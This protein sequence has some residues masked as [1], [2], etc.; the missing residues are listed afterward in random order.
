MAETPPPLER[1]DL[2]Q[3]LRGVAAA[4]IAEAAKLEQPRPEPEPWPLPLPEPE[5]EPPPPPAAL[6]SLEI[7]THDPG[8]RTEASPGAGTVVATTVYTTG[9]ARVS[10]TVVSG[11]EGNPWLGEITTQDTPG[12]VTV[13]TPLHETG[14]FVKYFDADDLT[15]NRDSAPVDLTLAPLPEPVVVVAAFP[16]AARFS[17]ARAF[18]ARQTIGLNVERLRPTTMGLGT[19]YYRYLG[20]LGVTHCRFFPPY[21]YDFMMGWAGSPNVG[22]IDTFLDRVQCCLDAGLQAYLDM[23]DVV[24]AAELTN[25]WSTATD[26]IRRFAGRIA[27]RQMDPAMIAVGAFNELAGGVNGDFNALRLEA[28]SIIHEVLP[29]H[30]TVSGGAYWN[31]IQ[32][33]EVGDW[34]APA[35]DQHIAQIHYYGAPGTYDWAL[36][37]AKFQ[38]LGRRYGG[39]PFVL[40]ELADAFNHTDFARDHGRWIEL[41]K[42]VAT[43][44]GGLRPMLWAQAGEGSDFRLNRSATDARMQPLIEEAIRE[45]ATIIKQTAGP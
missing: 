15:L 23:F 42:Q 8:P 10:S 22:T 34:A 13:F 33:W 6:R 44:A 17:Q 40:G 29:A 18:L 24:G 37:Y 16:A 7:E 36:G 14:A 27:A 41:F 28:D 21:R 5:S 30:L 39:M 1:A 19:D 2:A 12:V 31:S 45:C 35:H 25:N 38:A 11:A 3:L 26:Y 9:V 4:L 20:E 32:G 43:G